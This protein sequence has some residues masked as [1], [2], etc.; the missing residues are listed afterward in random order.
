MVDKVSNWERSARAKY[1][2]SQAIGVTVYSHV[3]NSNPAIN[4]ANLLILDDA[5]AAEQYVSGPWTLSIDRQKNEAAYL[6]VLS[7]A[8]DG[9]DPA[10]SWWQASSGTR[11]PDR[12]TRSPH[13]HSFCCLHNVALGFQHCDCGW[14]LG[15]CQAFGWQRNVALL[16]CAREQP[17]SRRHRRRHRPSG[18]IVRS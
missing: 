16:V 9:L 12:C 18:T 13:R 1:I 6:D 15:P 4:D 3:F 10:V 5:H 7:A 8:A 17:I 14:Q 2:A 11:Q